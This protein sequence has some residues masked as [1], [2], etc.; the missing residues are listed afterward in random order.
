MWG[1]LN[2]NNPGVFYWQ[3]VSSQYRS[4][5]RG[6]R[7]PSRQYKNLGIVFP[8]GWSTRCCGWFTWLC[9]NLS[10]ERRHRP[11]HHCII[12]DTVTSFVEFPLDF[13]YF[14][15]Y[16]FSLSFGR[17]IHPKYKWSTLQIAVAYFLLWICNFCSSVFSYTGMLHYWNRSN[18]SA[19]TWFLYI[20]NCKM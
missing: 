9:M 8:V 6:G 10:G 17:W 12:L 11:F 16:S 19:N 2:I 7:M 3:K 1:K 14:W 5:Q 20:F 13:G 15:R 4:I 18:C